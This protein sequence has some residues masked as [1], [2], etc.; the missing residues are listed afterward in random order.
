M[1]APSG[2]GS[3]P[4]RVRVLHGYMNRMENNGE[5]IV[6]GD[7]VIITRTNDRGRVQQI[8][9]KNAVI[10]LET[11]SGDEHIVTA[12]RTELRRAPSLTK[13]EEPPPFSVPVRR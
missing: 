3:V 4:R 9:E 7:E 6:A 8:D 13:P 2:D 12:E 1:I 5:T 11:R 10:E